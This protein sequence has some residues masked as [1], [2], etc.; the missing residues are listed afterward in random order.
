MLSFP[1]LRLGNTEVDRFNIATALRKDVMSSFEKVAD[2]TKQGIYS[3]SNIQSRKTRTYIESKTGSRDYQKDKFNP[4]IILPYHPKLKNLRKDIKSI[5]ESNTRDFDIE[6]EINERKVVLKPTNKLKY[7]LVKSHLSTSNHVSRKN[8]CQ[9]CKKPR[10][11]T[12]VSVPIVDMYE[13]TYQNKQYKLNSTTNCCSIHIIYVV[14]CKTC[15]LQYVENSIADILSRLPIDND[16]ETSDGREIHLI[17]DHNAS[18]II[19]KP[20]KIRKES[21]HDD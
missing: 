10:C 1:K 11:K 18:N 5:K 17:Q 6:N 4:G 15:R 19:L 20:D 21:A 9:L 8:A 12:C 13:S 2:R 14:T 3:P 16:N 7:M